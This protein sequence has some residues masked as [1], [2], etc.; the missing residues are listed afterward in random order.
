MPETNAKD[1]IAWYHRPLVVILLM[2][3]VLGPFALPLLFKSPAFSYRAKVILTVLVLIYT[4][5]LCIG[6]FQ[7]SMEISQK[8]LI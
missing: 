3:V 4:A 5:V 1:N 7:A 8:L 2:F 6:S